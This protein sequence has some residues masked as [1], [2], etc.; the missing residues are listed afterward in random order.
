MVCF[1]S[2]TKDWEPAFIPLFTL[3]R[4]R[5]RSIRAE[6][7]EATRATKPSSTP[8]EMD[9]DLRT[10]YLS[11]SAPEAMMMTETNSIASVSAL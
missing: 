10:D 9:E 2:L 7:K 6:R 4:L 8:V 1:P 11:I 5:K 3:K